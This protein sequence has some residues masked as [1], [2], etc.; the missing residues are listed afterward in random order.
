M[1]STWRDR[2]RDFRKQLPNE[3]TTLEDLKVSICSTKAE[4]KELPRAEGPQYFDLEEQVD[5]DEVYPG[6]YIGDGDTAKQKK[7]LQ[8]LGITHLINAAAGPYFG[9]VNTN[10]NYY[11]DTPIKYLGLPIM[12]SPTT[13]ISVYFTTVAA[14]IDEALSNGG[15]VFVHCVQGV[16]R[17]ATCVLAYLMI[18]K[19][20]LAT[21]AIKAVRKVRNIYPNRG[22]LQQLAELD[23][24]LRRERM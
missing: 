7:Y 15:K 24:Q 6:I 16:S 8:L 20:M 13:D 11:K 5:C 19:K 1:R 17:S 12:D 2:D 3:R 18:K 14:F 21:D 10:R 22:F 4:I 9:C 23:N